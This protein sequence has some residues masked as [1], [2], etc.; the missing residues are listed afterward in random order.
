MIP[1]FD[2]TNIHLGPITIHGWGLFVALGM[3]LGV[4]VSVNEA[5]AQKIDTHLIE[6]WAFWI[7]G[8][9]LIGARVMHFVLL[10]ELTNFIGLISIWQ[11]G[12]AS[13]GGIVG[14]I[15]TGVVLILIKA[16]KE[17]NKFRLADVLAGGF[18]L[19]MALGRLGC[20]VIHD[21]PGVITDFFLAVNFPSGPRLDMGLMESLALWPFG[22]MLYAKRQILRSKP[23]LITVYTF[24]IYG[25]IRFGLD[26]FRARDLAFADSRWFDLTLAQYFAMILVIASLVLLNRIRKTK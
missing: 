1:Y 24:G 10:G 12:W 23:G 25:L 6:S 8:G 26:F 21:H 22:I 16:P 19:G 4:K 20:F 3:L 9:A 17:I 7:L 5:R 13:T 2:L 11:L 15:L 18:L 14:A